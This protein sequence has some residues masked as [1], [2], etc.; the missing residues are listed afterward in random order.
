MLVIP[1]P[2]RGAT[3]WKDLNLCASLRKHLDFVS[4]LAQTLRERGATFGKDLDLC[5]SFRKQLDFVSILAQTL[6]TG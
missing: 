3:F 5:A 4:T 1:K 6:L 2:E